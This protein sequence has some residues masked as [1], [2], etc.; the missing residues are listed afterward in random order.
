M[1]AH[2]SLF[3]VSRYPPS[4][5]AEAVAEASTSDQPAPPRPQV[6]GVF[7]LCPMVEASPESRPS[8]IVE[9][10]AKSIKF[11]AGSLPLAKA[12]RGNVSDDP[13]VEEDF[14]ADRE[15]KEPLRS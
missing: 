2:I 15:L 14:F 3:Y 11:F 4:E 9:Y 1:P 12:V 7:A 13:R 10:L 8:A 6:A 5:S